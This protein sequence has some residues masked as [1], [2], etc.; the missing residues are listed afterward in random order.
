MGSFVRSSVRW[1]AS[2]PVLRCEFRRSRPAAA[3]APPG[4]R[5][6]RGPSGRGGV[7]RGRDGE[8]FGGA[9][10]SHVHGVGVAEPATFS[11]EVPKTIGLV[12]IFN[13]PKLGTIY[14]FNSL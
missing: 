5:P 13:H 11:L 3:P 6:F 2:T 8:R 12:G 1:T 10:A 9:A 4:R 7:V 14:N